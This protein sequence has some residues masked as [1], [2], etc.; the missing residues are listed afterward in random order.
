MPLA[1]TRWAIMGT[2]L[3]VV[4]SSWVGVGQKRPKTADAIAEAPEVTDG[5]IDGAVRKVSQGLQDVTTNVRDGYDKMR[6]ASRNAALVVEV[7]A[8][9]RQDKSLDSDRIDVVVED[10]GTVIH[11]GQVPDVGSKEMAVDLT[12]DIRGVERV[13][14]RLAVPPRPR[15]F[16]A[17]A[18]EA[19]ATASRPRRTTTR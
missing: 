10:E 5:T 2:V 19:P 7:N 4:G 12:R 3:G 14:D 6:G 18:D 17:K 16:A 11:K 8:R 15:V 13:E 1:R 9:L